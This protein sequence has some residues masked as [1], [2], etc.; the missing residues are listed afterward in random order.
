MK[1]KKAAAFIMSLVM[2]GSFGYGQ[3][4]QGGYAVENVS[5]MAIMPNLIYGHLDNYTFEISQGQKLT[6]NDLVE[7][8]L[9]IYK[10]TKLLHDLPYD[11]RFGE[12]DVKTD[13]LEP[14]ECDIVIPEILSE[15]NYNVHIVY[16]LG[17]SGW[18]VAPPSGTLECDINIDVSFVDNSYQ[19][20]FE[21]VEFYYDDDE[22]QEMQRWG[23]L[24]GI[25][26]NG[27]EKE[28]TIPEKIQDTKVKE[29]YGSSVNCENI[30]SLIIPETVFEIRENALYNTESLKYVTLPQSIKNIVSLGA[31]PETTTI[32]GHIGS[33]SEKYASKNGYRFE[34]IGDINNDGSFNSADMLKMAA[35]MYGISEL[36]DGMIYRADC[37][38]DSNV[39]IV[40]LILLKEN[41]I[42]PK[43]TALGASM[44][45]AAAV[46]DLESVKRSTDKIDANGYLDFASETTGKILLETEDKKGEENTVYS[47]LSV[48]MAYS[49]AAE[50]AGEETQEEFLNVLGSGNINDLRT[51]NRALFNSLYFDD[52][53]AYLKI[54]NSLWLN[55][56]YIFEQDTLDNIAENYYAVAFK[57]NFFAPETPGEISNWI[58]KNTSGKFRPVIK[59]DK[60][61]YEIMKIINTVTFKEKWV[62]E[63]GKARKDTFHL[64]DGTDIECDF[65]YRETDTP[66]EKIGFADNYMKYSVAMSDNYK[67]NFILPDEGISIDEITKD[68]NAVHDIYTD[69]NIIYENKGIIFKLPKFDVESNFNLVETSKKLGIELAFDEVKANFEPIVEYKKNNIPGAYISD[70][71]HEAKVVIDEKGCEAAAYTIISMDAATA[72]PPDYDEPVRFELNRPF[73]YY[74]SDT[75]GTPVFSGIIN[76]PLEK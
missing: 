35:Y 51:E 26:F 60:P 6:V 42:N 2:A 47:P 41:I 64:K 49:M 44:A 7:H 8:G 22:E 67:M 33:F 50:C 75:N 52:Y 30:E 68:K 65:L 19:A 17:D 25:K 70:I 13:L 40:D 62:D 15:G 4:I 61:K 28:E 11:D 58:Y 71:E 74:I 9:T 14:G 29:I 16:D 27:G 63:F 54:A 48:Y 12:Y 46:P 1:F 66:T 55:D 31:D 45:D 18:A 72:C 37:N 57:K 23:V 73:F 34:G 39:N 38:L 20:E 56:R 10:E 24:Y 3:F 76:N 69:E 21:D 5:A 43:M 59:I 36:D 53:N 32:R